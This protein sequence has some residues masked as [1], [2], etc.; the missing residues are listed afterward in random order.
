MT[1]DSAFVD[2]NVLLRA[3]TPQMAL[4]VETEALIQRLWAD[5][6]VMD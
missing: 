1:G 6:V 5:G 4:H 2:T 3:M